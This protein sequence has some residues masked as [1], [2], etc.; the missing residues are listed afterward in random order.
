MELEIPARYIELGTIK[1]QHEINKN[2][3]FVVFKYLKRKIKNKVFDKINIQL[4]QNSIELAEIIVENDKTKKVKLFRLLFELISLE[5]K[6]NKKTWKRDR[7][8]VKWRTDSIVVKIFPIRIIPLGF[9]TILELNNP[10]GSSLKFFVYAS[11]I[12]VAE[13]SLH[14]ETVDHLNL[15]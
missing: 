15:K 6:K 2:F 10:T 8:N 14:W 9:G 4:F 13:S 1:R 5:S 12:F 7:T 11:Q 3:E